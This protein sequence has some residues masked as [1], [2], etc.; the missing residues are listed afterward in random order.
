[1]EMR[2]CPREARAGV[3][4]HG[5]AP[6]GTVCP[7]SPRCLTTGPSPLPANSGSWRLVPVAPPHGD[8]SLR[9]TWRLVAP[10]GESPGSWADQAP[11][12]PNLL[13]RALPPRVPSPRCF[14]HSKSSPWSLHTPS[15]GSRQ[16]VMCDWSTPRPPP[17]A[18]PWKPRAP[19]LIRTQRQGPRRPGRRQ[20]GARTCG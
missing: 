3:G 11:R 9:Q 1:M 19:R 6:L 18:S 13:T 10:G 2:Q 16:A 4:A 17:A 8:L 12:P 5:P 7:L 15:T 14:E 20:P